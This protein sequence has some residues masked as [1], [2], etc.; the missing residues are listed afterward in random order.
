[1]CKTP[2]VDAFARV[3][4]RWVEA[5]GGK[6]LRLKGQEGLKKFK[7][8]LAG[9]SVIV[10]ALFSTYR[11]RSRYRQMDIGSTEYRVDGQ[12]DTRVAQGVCELSWLSSLT[13]PDEGC[14][15]CRPCQR[16]RRS[17]VQR[18]PRFSDACDHRQYIMA[19]NERALVSRM[20]I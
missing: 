19:V 10:V 13:R 5:F 7:K 1:M 6:E 2:L 11:L 8:A 17:L 9:E 16:Q 3:D 14:R 20:R 15:M 12:G 4:E 18:T